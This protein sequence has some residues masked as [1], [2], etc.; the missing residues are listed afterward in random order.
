MLTDRTVYIYVDNIR[1]LSRIV[2]HCLRCQE[3]LNS[4]ANSSSTAF[5]SDILCLYQRTPLHIA[6]KGGH[7]DIVKY[8]VEEG[9]NVNIKDQLGVSISDCSTE[10]IY[11]F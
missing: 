10:G 6:A 4:L 1:S 2:L 7:C 5:F 11:P 3:F 8:L 9:A